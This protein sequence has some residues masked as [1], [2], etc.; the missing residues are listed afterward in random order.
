MNQE[1]AI[2]RLFSIIRGQVL[3]KRL[4]L[5]KERKGG[6]GVRSQLPV[7]SCQLSDRGAVRYQ[8]INANPPSHSGNA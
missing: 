1:Y 2:S 8:L 3:R 7:V 5:N 4:I 6:G